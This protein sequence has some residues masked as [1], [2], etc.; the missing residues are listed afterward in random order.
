MRVRVRV[1]NSLCCTMLCY[2][3]GCCRNCAS[4]ARRSI[5]R[6][7]CKSVVPFDDLS[8]VVPDAAC[9]NGLVY[10]IGPCGRPG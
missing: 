7:S 1:C 3:H 10:I 9:Q 5:S 2:F 4:L 8:L 6:N